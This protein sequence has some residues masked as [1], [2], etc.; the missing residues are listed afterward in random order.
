MVNRDHVI[1]I[2]S[3]GMLTRIGFV[4]LQA[5]GVQSLCGG[6]CKLTACIRVVHKPFFILFVKIFFW[7]G[8]AWESLP[9]F[10]IDS[11]VNFELLYLNFPSLLRSM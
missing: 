2:Q 6:G 4:L 11:W 9:C 3:H 5:N 7:G 10:G 1:A 8:G